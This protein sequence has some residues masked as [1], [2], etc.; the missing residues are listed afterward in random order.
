[1]RSLCPRRHKYLSFGCITE[2][3]FPSPKET[4]CTKVHLREVRDFSRVRL[5]YGTQ[6]VVDQDSEEK[7]LESA[8]A[9]NKTLG[10]VE[11]VDLSDKSL[12]KVEKIDFFLL[13]EL[14][15]RDGYY[16]TVKNAAIFDA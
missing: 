12:Y 11:N 15:K 6:F 2:T 10:E 5:H 3:K 14:F 4:T 1:M 8:I 16:K 7:A 13:S 9:V